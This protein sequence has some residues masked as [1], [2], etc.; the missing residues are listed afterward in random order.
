M[1]S[2]QTISETR[3]TC[4]LPPQLFQP[5]QDAKSNSVSNAVTDQSCSKA[6]PTTNGRPSSDFRTGFMTGSGVQIFVKQSSLEGAKEL[7]NQ[8]E[9]EV[10]RSTHT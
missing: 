8:L 9:T 1:F 2:L 7:F 6:Q 5:E 3:K 4:F 10:V